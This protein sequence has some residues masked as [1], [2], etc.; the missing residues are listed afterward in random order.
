LWDGEDY[1]DMEEIY[2][3]IRGSKPYISG[4]AISGGEPTEQP[5]ALQELL[6]FIKNEGLKSCVHTRTGFVG[7]DVMLRTTDGIEYEVVVN[8]E[9]V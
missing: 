7:G 3:M 5:E 2:E 8:D 6:A 1:R 9:K 4:V